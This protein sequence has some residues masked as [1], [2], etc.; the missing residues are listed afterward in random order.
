MDPNR[1]P[2]RQTNFGLGDSYI[3][4][5]HQ[6]LR[7]TTAMPTFS[8]S[9][10]NTYAPQNPNV[11][12][13]SNSSPQYHIDTGSLPPLL[14]PDLITHVQPPSTFSSIEFI[15]SLGD[16]GHDFLMT[17]VSDYLNLSSGEKIISMEPPSITSLLQGNPTATLHAHFSIDGMS[18]PN[19]IFEE[20]R[21]HVSKE[22]VFVSSS[23]LN[24]NTFTSNYMQVEEFGSSCNIDPYGQI[25]YGEAKCFG[26]S[27][28]SIMSK[29]NNRCL[30]MSQ[31]KADGIVKA[32]MST[33]AE[34]QVLRIENPL[35]LL[36]EMA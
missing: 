21:L 33:T 32:T 24:F 10:P 35:T 12:Q 26:Q 14:Q 15:Q 16:N 9:I 7:G 20:T 30:S 5:L 17:P 28:C 36:S 2:T 31:Q 6:A 34:A 8:S 25:S 27:H 13:T 29:G 18:D 22:E 23:N 1:S 11:T 4:P 3:S 19:P